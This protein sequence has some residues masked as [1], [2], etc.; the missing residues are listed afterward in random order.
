MR[1][2][3][4]QIKVSSL[5]WLDGDQIRVSLAP[6]SAVSLSAKHATFFIFIPPT[7]SPATTRATTIPMTAPEPPSSSASAAQPVG[8]SSSSQVTVVLSACSHGSISSLT[9][10][11]ESV[12][13]QVYTVSP[14]SASHAQL[15]PRSSS[16]AH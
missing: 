10:P 16:T 5:R 8:K 9:T 6:P 2:N 7:T 11:S 12:A 14:S 15:S 13:V 3:G 4:D 1:L